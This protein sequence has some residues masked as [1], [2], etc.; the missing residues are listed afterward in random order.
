MR[1][2][3]SYKEI[4]WIPKL[5]LNPVS[6]IWVEWRAVWNGD[7]G[8]R[9]SYFLVNFIDGFLHFMLK[10]KWQK[11]QFCCWYIMYFFEK[12]SQVSSGSCIHLVQSW[13]HNTVFLSSFG[14]FRINGCPTSFNVSLCTWLFLMR[15]LKAP[16]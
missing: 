1:E 13:Y 12:V 11:G 6:E 4:C 15:S 9:V 7:I 14:A 16:G 10:R 2:F 5:L 3:T 8:L